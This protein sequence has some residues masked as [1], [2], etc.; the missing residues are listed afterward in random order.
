MRSAVSTAA[1]TWRLCHVRAKGPANLAYEAAALAHLKAQGVQVALALP[2]RDGAFWREFA[3]SEG[4]RPLSLFEF[5]EG[6]PPREDLD[7]VERMGRELARIHL[8]GESFHGAESLYAMELD[9]LL[10]GPAARI[11]AATAE[12]PAL[13]ADF[14][15]ATARLEARLTACRSE[16]STVLCHGDCHGG[17]T[18]VFDGPD[19]ERVAGFFDFDE[20]G[21][22]CLSYELAVYPWYLL[23]RVDRHELDDA[24]RTRWLSFLSGYRAIRAIPPADLQA[25]SLFIPIRQ[26]WFLGEYVSRLPE[27]GT[28]MVSMSW[29]RAQC[30]L[31]M[32]WEHVDIPV[33]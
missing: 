27:W 15:A 1:D 28:S 29:L 10:S 30:D 2:A 14:A 20:A 33:A 7:G 3:T 32:N 22:G 5:L 21:P 18:H 17:N 26:I 4:P 6:A 16:L 11:V 13:Q 12:D 9:H 8:A 25:I 31:L 23:R 24:G 19:G